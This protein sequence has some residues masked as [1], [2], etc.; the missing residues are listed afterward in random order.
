M[1]SLLITKG[2]KEPIYPSNKNQRLLTLDKNIENNISKINKNEKNYKNKYLTINENNRNRTIIAIKKG[3][4]K[5]NKQSIELELSNIK[6]NF[7]ALVNSNIKKDKNKFQSIHNYSS[8]KESNL[9]SL[10]IENY[11]TTVFDKDKKIN[12]DKKKFNKTKNNIITLNNDDIFASKI[13]TKKSNHKNK[14]INNNNKVNSKKIINTIFKT[15]NINNKRKNK[16]KY[17]NKDNEE[18]LNKINISKKKDNKISNKNQKQNIDHNSKSHPF[19]N[20]LSSDKATSLT[21]KQQKYKRYIERTPNRILINNNNHQSKKNNNNSKD[22][23][24][25]QSLNSKYETN[26]LNISSYNQNNISLSQKSNNKVRKNKYTIFDNR[27]LIYKTELNLNTENNKEILQTDRNSIIKKRDSSEVNNV[28]KTNNKTR[29]LS[30]IYVHRVH[31]KNFCFKKNDIIDIKNKNNYI[32]ITKKPCNKMT[33]KK[34]IRNIPYIKE[35][36]N[37]EYNEKLY[38]DTI[39]NNY[40][41]N[42]K[43]LVMIFDKMKQVNVMIKP[44]KNLELKLFTHTKRNPLI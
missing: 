15:P 42:T 21:S 44:R 19:K 16:I 1:K 13:I 10:A 33:K 29:Y 3:M 28:N 20:S 23:Y 17:I 22:D 37:D 4:N 12:E 43:K 36:Y 8:N 35:D 11:T 2:K 31:R 34:E 40:D 18:K 14:E 27:Q 38:E 26:S 6:K 39:D 24:L 5:N 7:L 32:F 25:R 41:L 9:D 30:P